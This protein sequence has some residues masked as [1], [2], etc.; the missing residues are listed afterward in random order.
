[1]GLVL[2]WFFRVVFRRG[3][4]L[5]SKDWMGFC[6]LLGFWLGVGDIEG[7]KIGGV[8]VLGVI[9]GGEG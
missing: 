2:Y 1:M 6:Y 5:G 8:F 4:F 3:F 9:F 7:K